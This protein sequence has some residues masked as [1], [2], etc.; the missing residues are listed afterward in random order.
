M[1]K[2]LFALSDIKVSLF[3]TLGVML[4]FFF[5]TSIFDANNSFLNLIDKKWVDFILNE[6]DEQPVAP[7]V[8]IAVI[9]TKSVDLYGRWPWPRERMAQ[10]MDAL[11]EYGVRTVGFDIV[12][13]EPEHNEG[14]LALGRVQ[15]LFRDLGVPDSRGVQNL[16]EEIVKLRKNLDGDG[17]LASSISKK[18][19]VVLGY[20]FFGS[21]GEVS[22]L[23]DEE[24]NIGFKR[25][26]GQEI[27]LVRG[28][29]PRYALPPG[30]APETNI[31]SISNNSKSHG[32]FNMTPDREDGTVR[33]VHLLYN[34]ND[35]IYP[36]LDL[37]ILQHFLG[38]KQLIVDADPE[39]GIL[40]IQVGEK[41]IYTS[42]DGSIQLNYKGPS[43]TFPHYSIYDIIERKVPKD[44]LKDKIV[45]IGP[46]EV[47]IYDLRTTPVEVAY[48]GVEVHA[49]LLDNLITDSYF[50]LDFANDLSTIIL[51]IVL[52]IGLGWVLPKM[53]NIYSFLLLAVLVGFYTYIHQWMVNHWLTWTS[54]IYV[55]MVMVMV[56]TGVTLYRFFVTDKDRR[57]IKGAFQQYLSPQVI[58]QLTENPDLL[59]LGGERRVLTAFFSDIQGF[60][61]ISEQMEPEDLVHLLNQYLT[62]MSDII[63]DYGGTV[64][65]YEGDAIIAFFG[66]PIPFEDHAVKACYVTL[67]MQKR[68]GELRE[69]WKSE[70]LPEILMRIGLNTGP[71]IVGNMGSQKRFDYTMMGNS[72]NLAA[73][74]E[75]A[76]KNYKM[77]NCISEYTYAAAKDS[78]ETREV[79]LI[80]VLGINAPVQIYEL[81]ARKGELNPEQQAGFKHFKQ[82][83]ALYRQQDWDHAINAFK[84]CCQNL[85]DDPPAKVY[86]QRCLTYRQSP[87][88]PK[89]QVWDGVFSATSK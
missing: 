49:T 18:D 67:E 66:A 60:S 52:G 37:R 46:T 42:N 5:N 14:S 73:R 17:K 78:I 22:H 29:L 24:K 71:M 25:L 55:V 88:V 64:D 8:A 30:H 50:R 6:R 39:A 68:L 13:S 19:N 44:A 80:R 82:G 21:E 34:A 81:V 1:L 3:I 47:G 69:I 54:Y 65:K 10:M 16:R 89:G 2:R 59:K 11:N 58:E 75:G 86:I 57:F 77:Y 36:S 76:N 62:E 43:R 70:G 40:G 7:E 38:A 27:N 61:T 4:T 53:K 63:T 33:R 31:G 84:A 35:S 87:P 83:L 32:F 79:D 51:I 23:G 74:L 72:V 48:P 20:F 45:L 15:R 12:F 56:W 28:A 41:Y 85:P 26:A 9:D